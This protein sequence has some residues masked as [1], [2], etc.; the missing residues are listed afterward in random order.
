MHHVLLDDVG[1]LTRLQFRRKH[2]QDPLRD[3]HIKTNMCVYIYIYIFTYTFVPD[4]CYLSSAT[5]AVGRRV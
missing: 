5:Y 2:A 4:F 3:T 1:T